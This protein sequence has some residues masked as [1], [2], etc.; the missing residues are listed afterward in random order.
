MNM[1]TKRLF[2]ALLCL[3]AFAL[4]TN[5]KT[6]YVS[7]NGNNTNDGTSWAKAILT[8]DTA[9]VRAAAGDN[10]WVLGDPDGINGYNIYTFKSS[11]P[12]D[13]KQ[14]F[15]TGDLNWFGGFKGNE[16]SLSQRQLA[17]NDGNGIVEPWEFVYPTKISF[18]LSNNAL[19]FTTGAS[20]KRIIDGFTFYPGTYALT[21]TF[22]DS[23]LFTINPNAVLKNS[24]IRDGSYTVTESTGN[25]TL[26]PFMWMR[27]QMDYCLMENNTISASVLLSR[28]QYA[29]L[30]DV[31][32]HRGATYI[33]PSVTNCVFR[34]NTG[35]LD[36]S[37]LTA[38][39][40]ETRGI[41]IY[42]N[43]SN[44][45]LANTYPTVFAN[46]LLY[47][48]DI[49]FVGNATLTSISGGIVGTSWGNGGAVGTPSATTVMN[50][51]FAKNKITNIKTPGVYFAVSAGT[52]V[53]NIVNNIFYSNAKYIGTTLQDV[54]LQNNIDGGN[55]SLANA[56][57][58][59]TTDKA[60]WWGTTTADNIAAGNGTFL[61]AD[62]KFVS[63]SSVVGVSDL[64]EVTKANWSLLT[65]SPFVGKGTLSSYN[66]AVASA[67]ISYSKDFSGRSYAEPRSVGAFEAGVVS[68]VTP[69]TAINNPII[70]NIN[71]VVPVAGGLKITENGNI[72]VISMIGQLV[73]SS[74]VV[75]GQVLHLNKGIYLVRLQSTNGILVQKVIL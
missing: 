21:T 75:D 8:P 60:L 10:I 11:T 23:K 9:R 50:N 38:T 27:G 40:M 16:T 34:N 57:N 22:G 61:A 52:I 32:Y 72:Q 44:G 48:N 42:V 18:D 53:P 17:D 69:P 39:T 49:K 15:Q 65:G 59:Y 12:G 41:F 5:A 66:S 54:T 35:V 46:N 63:P 74:Q 24:I 31:D 20:V 25:S 62:A 2:S 58:N 68:V 43:G 7:Y 3:T 14:A 37:A 47:N 4:V 55:M 51:V 70:R 19:A 33:L 28:T 45:T 73:L 67:Y 64:I 36:G 26:R 56:F 1:K 6:I 29:L 71:F 30:F 13:G